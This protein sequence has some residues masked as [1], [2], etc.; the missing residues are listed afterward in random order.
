MTGIAVVI[1][2][3]NGADRLRRLLPQ[4]QASVVPTRVIVVDDGSTDE[5]VEV[6]SRL[7]VQVVA[8]ERN[9]GFAKAV[10][11]GI[12]AAQQA[13]WIAILNND[14]TIEPDFLA[15]LS[16][17]A[18]DADVWF[19]APKLL[20]S[21]SP[22]KMDGAFD[23]PARGGIAYRA[24]SGVPS[25]QPA[26]DHPSNI[27]CAPMT[28]AMF[29]GE[30]FDRIGPLDEAF[31]SYL[32]DVDFGIRCALAGYRGCYVPDAVAYHEGSATTGGSWS[33]FSTRQIS[34]NQ[35]LLARKFPCGWWPAV[36]GQF[37]WGVLALRHGVPG[38]WLRGK[39]EG[40]RTPV[41]RQCR[42]EWRPLV[43][44]CEREIV[45]LQKEYGWDWFWRQYFR[46]VPPQAGGRGEWGPGT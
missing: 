5:S 13:S 38:P 43:L 19:A 14:V 7:G 3:Y 4:V 1:P 28:A 10:N 42:Q 31:G 2:N 20:S 46:L 35:V 9:F 22:G 16:A 8:L 11:T 45:A 44:A 12:A 21:K 37:L 18:T 17:G 34:R 32:E 41:S 33:A 30:L 6:S 23:L 26:F 39:I 24:G 25:D 29:R 27:I 36:W 15:R 40:L